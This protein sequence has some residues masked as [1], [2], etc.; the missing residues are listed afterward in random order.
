MSNTLPN[1]LIVGAQ[2]C[3]TTSLHEILAAHSEAGM[4]KVKEINFF[5][6]PE[7]HKKG[8]Q[9]Y[10]SFFEDTKGKIIG[11]SSP[12]YICYP[13]VADLIKEELGQV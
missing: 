10:S 11:E 7:K 2:K 3:G 12:G 4:S 9:Y 1:F 8:L 13:G 5:T 6:N